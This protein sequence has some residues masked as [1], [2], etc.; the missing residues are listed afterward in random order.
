MTD[1]TPEIPDRIGLGNVQPA[2]DAVPGPNRLVN[3]AFRALTT[4]P[5]TPLTANF[6]TAAAAAPA[7]GVGPVRQEPQGL[8]VAGTENTPTNASIFGPMNPPP[9]IFAATPL[10]AP[11]IPR[12]SVFRFRRFQPRSPTRHQ[13]PRIASPRTI[14]ARM[15]GTRADGLA[16]TTSTDVPMTDAP[17][18]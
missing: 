5:P 1:V 12:T 14:R 9:R 15:G 3:L 13:L 8:P 4:M 16:S 10:R 18:E 11:A 17:D 2:I 6:P 7:G